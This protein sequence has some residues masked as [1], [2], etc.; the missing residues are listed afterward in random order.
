M[1][2][3][4]SR[5]SGSFNPTCTFCKE[6]HSSEKCSIMK[7]SVPR[8]AILQLFVYV[9]AI[10]RVNVD[11]KADISNVIQN[12]IYLFVVFMVYTAV[13]GLLKAQITISVTALK[14]EAIT[15]LLL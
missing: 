13:M 4:Y 1:Y 3:C 9:P 15:I 11:L 12:I 6:N 2:S 7:D 14:M 8:K 5:H 10:K